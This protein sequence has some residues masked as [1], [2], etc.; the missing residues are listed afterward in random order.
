MIRSLA[1]PA[2]M[3]SLALAGARAAETGDAA[4]GARVFRACAACHSLE[5]DRNLTGPLRALH[6]RTQ[7]GD[8]SAMSRPWRRRPIFLAQAPSDRRAL[9]I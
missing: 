6:A 8:R 5:P 4:R 2:L 7:L 1:A 3:T 9:G